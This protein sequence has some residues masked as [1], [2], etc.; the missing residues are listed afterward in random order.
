MLY[1]VEAYHNTSHGQCSTVIQITKNPKE[2]ILTARQAEGLGYEFF[3]ND[4]FVCV[5]RLDPERRYHKQDFKFNNDGPPPDHPV[6]FIRRRRGERDRLFWEEEWFG[7]E[8]LELRREV[9]SERISYPTPEEVAA[10]LGIPK[11]EIKERVK[12]VREAIGIPE[13][14]EREKKPVPEKKTS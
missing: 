11:E 1:V 7:L 4:V 2:A 8:A 14:T 3:E 12:K 5:Y 13:E 9:G 10:I 6:L